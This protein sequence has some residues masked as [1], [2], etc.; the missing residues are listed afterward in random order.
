MTGF[1]T[2]FP[3]YHGYVETS[4]LLLELKHLKLSR[5]QETEADEAGVFTTVFVSAAILD[6]GFNYV[7]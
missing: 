5:D 7:K 1:R 4:D 6:S 3:V 2:A